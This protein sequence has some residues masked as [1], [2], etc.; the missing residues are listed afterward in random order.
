MEC[1]VWGDASP[2]LMSV[3]AK[4]PRSPPPSL[5]LAATAVE[6]QNVSGRARKPCPEARRL[7]QTGQSLPP[8]SLD[9]VFSGELRSTVV[10]L[11]CGAVSCAT[12]P[13][14]DI[15]LPIPSKL[16]RQQAPPQQAEQAQ[17]AAGAAGSAGFE[18]DKARDFQF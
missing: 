11:T 12:E 6:L 4:S 14:L 15:S 3:V 16:H 18:G 1:G 13:C 8:R 9:R 5:G 17:T 2:L 10:C 7:W